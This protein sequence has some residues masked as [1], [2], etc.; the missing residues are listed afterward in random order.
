VIDPTYQNRPPVIR[1]WNRH[2]LGVPA[3]AKD[4]D[5]GFDL[6][7]REG[8]ILN[9]GDRYLA[10]TGVYLAIAAVWLLGRVFPS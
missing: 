6:R 5:A 9:P 8:F 1:M 2:F 10:P 7:T 4:R 3:Y